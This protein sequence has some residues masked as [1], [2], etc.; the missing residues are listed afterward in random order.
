MRKCRQAPRRVC[1]RFGTS[2]SIKLPVDARLATSPGLALSVRVVRRSYVR[3][4]A[5]LRTATG[6]RVLS[7]KDRGAE[8]EITAFP[9]DR[10][11]INASVAYF[12]FKSDGGPKNANGTTNFGYV[13]PSFDVQA[14]YTGSLGMQYTFRVGGGSPRQRTGA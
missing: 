8:L 14:K 7:G 13:D 10:L 6:R 4:N 3:P 1:E 5:A 2:G 9:I 11:A 12:D